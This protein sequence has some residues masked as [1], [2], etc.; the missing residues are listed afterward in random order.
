MTQLPKILIVDDKEQNL[1]ALE[2]LLREF[3]VEVLRATSGFDALSLVLENEFC[4]AIVDV[5]MPG[6]DGYELVELLRGNERT[7]NLPIIFVSAIYSDEYHHRKGY[8]SG[9]ID[10]LSKPFIPEILLSKVEIFIALY[11]QRLKLEA[12]VQEVNRT[13]EALSRQTWQLQTSAQVSRQITSILDIETLLSEVVDLIRVRFDYYFAGVWLLDR[14]KLNVRLRASSYRDPPLEVNSRST[15]IAL[16]GK[17]SIIAHVCHTTKAYLADGVKSDDNYL[18]I[19]ELPNVSSELVL[20]LMVGEKLLGVL[21]FQSDHIAA[22][23][24]LDVTVLQTLTD[25]IAIA[26]R[27]A[28]LYTGLEDEVKERTSEL[29]KAYHH[30]E[31]LDLNKSNF[32]QVVAHELRT[33]LTVVKGFSQMLLR[34]DLIQE[35]EIYSRQVEGIVSGAERMHTIVNSMLDIIKID[36]QALRLLPQKLSLANL[37]EMLQQSLS[38]TLAQRNLTMTL[39]DIRT[40]P[41]IE[42]DHEALRKMFNHVVGNAIKYTPDGGAIII[43]GSMIS[44]ESGEPPT[45]HNFVKID[46][47]DTGIGIDPAVQDLIFTKFYQTGSAGEHSSGSTKF[48]GGGPGLGLA[49]ARGIAI[50]HGGQVWVESSG[51]DEEKCPGS[52]FYIVLPTTQKEG[53]QKQI[54]ESLTKSEKD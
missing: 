13:N 24:E 46:V 23:S 28:E 17:L 10:F 26:I 8:D 9:A 5:Q 18:A 33:P 53:Y 2:K 11:D 7:S 36:S 27:N 45:P 6:M 29:Q 47:H 19:A 42:A 43:T 44:E 50:A 20:P 54:L 37:L 41:D 31:L 22:F 39:V 51:C 12:M 35:H 14:P 16:D 34:A 38:S 48:K 49:I 15:S 3:S 30:L 52:T 32:I 4:V 40:L 1:Y 21:D 25:Q